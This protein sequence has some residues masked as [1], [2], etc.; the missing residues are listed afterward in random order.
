M[1]I[2]WNGWNWRPGSRNSWLL[3]RRQKELTRKLVEAIRQLSQ[4]H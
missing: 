1:A 2:N 4:G 3:K